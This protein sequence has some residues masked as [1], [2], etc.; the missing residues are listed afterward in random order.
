V[1][2]VLVAFLW[3]NIHPARV[4]MG[5]SGAFA[6]GW[7]L[8]LVVLYLNMRHI[9]IL[10]PFICFFMLCSIELMTSFIQLWSK[11]FLKRKFFAIAPFHHLLEHHGMAEQTIVMRMRLVQGILIML[12]LIVF[13]YTIG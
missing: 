7:L 8:S 1:I 12:G 9:P 2:A 10:I 3:Y 4:F 5:D 13:F 6:L 11:K